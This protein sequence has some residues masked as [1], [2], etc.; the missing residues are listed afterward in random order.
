[1]GEV[2]VV[3]VVHPAVAEA[4][5]TVAVLPADAVHGAG[6]AVVVV[7]AMAVLPAEADAVLGAEEVAVAVHRAE[8]V[9]VR[10][11]DNLLSNLYTFIIFSSLSSRGADL[12]LLLCTLNFPV[13]HPKTKIFTAIIVNPTPNVSRCGDNR[14]GGMPSFQRGMLL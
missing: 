6:E 4:I 9:A 7:G 11:E 1:V 2:A 14:I 12:F 8:A 5:T 3:T 10:A 13:W